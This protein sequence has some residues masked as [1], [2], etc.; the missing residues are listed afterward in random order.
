MT[1]EQAARLAEME[2]Q[3]EKLNDWL[4]GVD[5]GDEES[6]ATIIMKTCRDWNTTQDRARFGVRVTV[7]VFGVLGGWYAGAGE[8]ITKL[9][10]A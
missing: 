6:R 3:M 9:F 4:F 7:A 1:E 5:E 8:I 2:G 10:K